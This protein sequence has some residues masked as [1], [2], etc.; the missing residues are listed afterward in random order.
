MLKHWSIWP[1]IA[2][3][4]IGS[5]LYFSVPANADTIAD[6]ALVETIRLDSAFGYM[7]E[8]QIIESAQ[9][10]CQFRTRHTETQTAAIVFRSTPPGV[11][12]G[13]A[14]YFLGAAEGAYCPQYAGVSA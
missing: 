4:I 3:V 12:I 7:S 1:I 14:Y 8:S 11:G 9:E 6:A 2:G 5:A 10:V 13:D